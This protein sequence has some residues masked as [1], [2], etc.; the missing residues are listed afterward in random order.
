MIHFSLTSGH[1]KPEMNHFSLTSDH[2]K[3][4]MN[5][6]SLTSGHCK[7]ESDHF[8]LTSDRFMLTLVRSRPAMRSIQATMNHFSLT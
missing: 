2:C 5:H 4:E 7:P 8:S 3:P 1:C 6:F